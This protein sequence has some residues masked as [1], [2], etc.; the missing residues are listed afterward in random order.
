MAT[1]EFRS[2]ECF[3][4]ALKSAIGKNRSK[5]SPF[6]QSRDLIWGLRGGGVTVGIQF[7]A[8]LRRPRPPF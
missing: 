3:S 5:P 2:P 4:E 7:E 8:A 1:P 6:A